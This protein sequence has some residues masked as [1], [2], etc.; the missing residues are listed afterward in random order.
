MKGVRIAGLDL[1]PYRNGATEWDQL[2]LCPQCAD[3][4]SARDPWD[5]GYVHPTRVEVNQGGEV[6]EVTREGPGF[7]RHAARGRGS[8][9]T[10][11]FWCE[12]SHQFNLVFQFHKGATYVWAELRSPADPVAGVVTLWR[13]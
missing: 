2:V 6:V 9:I 7:A 5:A 10:L 13:D 3:E 4:P 12:Q 11:S 1:R 8:R